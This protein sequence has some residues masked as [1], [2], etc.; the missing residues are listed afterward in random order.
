MGPELLSTARPTP[1]RLA[2]FLAL[3]LGG[4][5]V[6]LGSIQDWAIVQPFSTPTRGIDV[7]E[8]KVT[9]ALGIAVLAGIVLIRIPSTARARTWGAAA[10]VALGLV[11]MALAGLD[12]ARAHDRFTDPAQRDRIA[13]ALAQQ[14]GAGLS[15]A[16]IR[17]A[18]ERQFD[19]RFSV[20]LRAGI[21]LVMVGGMLTV[22]GGGLSIA[23]ARTRS[24]AP[25]TDGGA[26]PD[27]ADTAG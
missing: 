22:V 21:W 16:Q 1:L 17:A 27:R 13:H 6:A 5:L 9:I 14:T 25:P 11:A 10:I 4:G 2:G 20:D 26:P 18:I 12:V 8:G 7:W 3:V 19:Q 24:A 23:W 15:Y